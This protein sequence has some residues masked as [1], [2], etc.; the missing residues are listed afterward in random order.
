[1]DAFRQA[2]PYACGPAHVFTDAHTRILYT[3]TETKKL[4]GLFL[5]YNT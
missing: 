5:T 1:M 3:S 4:K 2:V